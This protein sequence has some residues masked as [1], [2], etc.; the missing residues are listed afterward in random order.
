MAEEIKP[1]ET[2]TEPEVKETP[3][4]ENKSETPEV[5]DPAEHKKV[6]EALKA[7]N[8]ESADRRKKLEAYEKAEQER[9]EA[10]M[11]ELEKAQ[12]RAAE[13]EAKVKESDLRELRRK[14]GTAHELPEAVYNLLPDL[15]EEEMTVKAK[16]VAA[17]LAKVTN[18]PKPDIKVTNPNGSNKTVTDAQRRAFLNG[19]PLPE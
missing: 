10:E 19:G 9:K 16:E 5:I 7:A 17:E 12:K 4:L 8:R 3:E 6:L 11:S 2:P 15:P 18:K 1:G 14:V 13:L